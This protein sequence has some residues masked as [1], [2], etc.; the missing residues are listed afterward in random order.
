M[1]ITDSIALTAAS[2]DK[3]DIAAGYR[4]VLTVFSLF[5]SIPAGLTILQF[6]P[7]RI[8]FVTQIVSMMSFAFMLWRPLN[9]LLGLPFI[10]LIAPT[11]GVIEHLG[12]RAVSCEWIMIGLT[13]NFAYLTYV[14]YTKN[15]V[16]IHELLFV[17]IYLM[18]WVLSYVLGSIISLTALY[19][20]YGYIVINYYFKNFA[21]G[22]IEWSAILNAWCLASVLGSLI[23]INAFMNGI[24]LVNFSTDLDM[25]ITVNSLENS[26]GGGYYYTGFKLIIGM[27]TGW[28]MLRLVFCKD[29]LKVKVILSFILV[30]FLM[31]LMTLLNRTA[32]LAMIIAIS[33]SF[34]YFIYKIQKTSILSM[35]LTF[36]VVI[37]F[38]YFFLY[39]FSLSY[40]DSIDQLF[41]AATSNNS[42][43]IRLDHWESAI[44]LM[45]TEYPYGLLLGLGP[46]FI[47]QGNQEMSELFRT[48]ATDGGIEGALDSTWITFFIEFGVLGFGFV[49]YIFIKCLKVLLGC[50]RILPK[51]Y[52]TTPVFIAIFYAMPYYIIVF[53]SQSVGYAKISWFPFQVILITLAYGTKLSARK[54]R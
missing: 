48:S 35:S 32:I 46:N 44:R 52:L 23:S 17:S 40:Y 54:K 29:V 26:F 1:N 3:H 47:E 28:I 51:E 49:V 22:E 8:S 5:W 15:K 7:A 16:R 31:E 38:F 41:G 21:K 18:S 24:S 6:D 2:K 36:I 25:E 33:V 39:S 50:V 43:L 20:L 12:I 30:V 10:A 11:G 42:F 4:T 53:V 14:N 27:L 34:I 37:L 19:Y 45:L 13:F 9:V